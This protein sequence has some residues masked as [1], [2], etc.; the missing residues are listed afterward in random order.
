MSQSG[1]FF[2]TC[3]DA[4]RA[5]NKNPENSPISYQ[6]L[7]ALLISKQIPGAYQ[8]RRYW[9]VPVDGLEKIGYSP[10]A[11]L[12]LRMNVPVSDEGAAA[13]V[14]DGT[15]EAYAL[16]ENQI[17]QISGEIIERHS[18]NQN[19]K[20]SLELEH[21]ILLD[22]ENRELSIRLRAAEERAE[23]AEE[24]LRDLRSILEFATNPN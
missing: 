23:Q 12:A 10:D 1:L 5:I 3:T 4:V 14:E 11:S 13:P 21:L 17:D 19:W 9:R 20:K 22:R 2:P 7:Y 8:D 24:H 15:P 6:E 16:S 18:A